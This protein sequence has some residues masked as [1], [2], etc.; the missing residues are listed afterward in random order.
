MTTI[1]PLWLNVHHK[2]LVRL[3]PL[4]CQAALRPFPATHRTEWP[5]ARFAGRHEQGTYKRIRSCTE[6]LEGAQSIRE[7]EAVT[8]FHTMDSPSSLTLKHGV[9]GASFKNTLNGILAGRRINFAMRKKIQPNFVSRSVLR[10]S[11]LARSARRFGSSHPQPDAIPV[12]GHRRMNIWQYVFSHRG[13]KV[14]VEPC[15]SKLSA[16]SS[17]CRPSSILKA[18]SMHS[19][20]SM[21]TSSGAFSSA[22]EDSRKTRLQSLASRTRSG[23]VIATAIVGIRINCQR[24]S[25][26]DQQAEQGMT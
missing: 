11:L 8:N 14:G 23:R 22:A 1:W 25:Q 15:V 5:L 10:P 26:R 6:G 3:R 17:S 12:L 13:T 21:R 16:N 9:E 7:P 4:P 2:P 20:R 18:V 19:M 24:I